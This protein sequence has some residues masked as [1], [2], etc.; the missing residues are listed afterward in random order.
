M[1]FTPAPKQ[2]KLRSI[3]KLFANAAAVG[4]GNTVFQDLDQRSYQN[5]F[6]QVLQVITIPNLNPNCKS[7]IKMPHKMPQLLV[8]FQDLDQNSIQK[9][10][11]F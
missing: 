10:F 4:T 1:L 6:T 5:Q 3:S 2:V 11:G 7:P 9:Q 8:K